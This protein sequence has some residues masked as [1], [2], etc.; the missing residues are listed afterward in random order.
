M[1]EVQE[2]RPPKKLGSVARVARK[3]DP[4]A[5]P[6]PRRRAVKAVA[7]PTPAKPAKTKAVK[8]SKALR[9]RT[10]EGPR[11][12]RGMV[13]LASGLPIAAYQNELMRKN[14]KA[15]LTDAQLAA[16][17]REEFPS[18]IPYT[19]KHVAGIRSGWNNG[20]RGN[21][22]PATPLPRYDEDGKPVTRGAG[23]PAKA[24][25]EPKVRAKSKVAKKG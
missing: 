9:E 17:M 18:A 7:D 5:P 24:P 23:R 16:A 22:A 21:E 14:F 19:E 12:S 25:A 20:K 13:G 3:T 1:S 4:T 2:A 6:A 8:E 15:K 11:G 10:T